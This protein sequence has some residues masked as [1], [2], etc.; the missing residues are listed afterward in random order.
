MY[1]EDIAVFVGISPGTWGAVTSYMDLNVFSAPEL[2]AVL[3]ALRQV[4]LANDRFTDAERALIEGVA[5]VHGVDIDASALEPISL[6][7]VAH[8][9]GDAHRRK[10]AVQLAIVTALVEGTP[11]EEVENAVERLATA[12]GVDEAALKVLYELTHGRALLARVDV[13]RRFSRFVRNAKDFPGIFQAA[14]PMLG[15]G[16]GD[17]ELAARYRAL[18][19]APSTSFGRAFYEHFT[20]N[21][22]KFPGEPGG[23]PLPFHDVGHVLSGYGTE[24][25][26]EIQQAAFQAGFARR[27]GFTFLLFGILQFHVGLRITPVAKGYHGLFDVPRVL[28]AL[29]RGARCNVDLSEGFDVFAYQDRPLEDVRRELGIPPLGAVAKAG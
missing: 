29:E 28:T 7:Q 26:G 14:L 22:F 20:K 1:G 16:G 23:L 4:A 6:E 27:D 24:P 9:V 3:R 17:K 5:R 21:Q 15:I 11:S 19:N 8:V 10:R 12:L 18:E 13:F 2:D 25:E